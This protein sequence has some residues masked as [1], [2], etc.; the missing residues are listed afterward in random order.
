LL[1][2]LGTGTAA[3]QPPTSAL[4]G[5]SPD[6]AFR[7]IVALGGGARELR[8][9]HLNSSTPWLGTQ[10]AY[11]VLRIGLVTLSDIDAGR[12]L[13]AQL[14]LGCGDALSEQSVRGITL[15]DRHA[16]ASMLSRLKLRSRWRNVKPTLHAQGDLFE[17][18]A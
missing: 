8:S 5:L 17:G 16:A 6:G 4:N 1:E 9:A 10:A 18:W 12:S 3:G 7:L 13:A 15:L 2:G 14:G 11:E